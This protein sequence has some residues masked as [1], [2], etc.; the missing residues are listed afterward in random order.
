M[1]KVFIC[2]F[3]GIGMEE[4]GK[5]GSELVINITITAII[6]VIVLA[7]LL[8]IFLNGTGNFKDKVSSFF[9]ASNV[10]NV[11]QICNNDA[12]QEGKYEY[13]CVKKL[14]RLSSK[15]KYELSCFEASGKSWASSMIKLNCE[16]VC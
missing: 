12:A 13:C 10:D 3:L 14:V 1:N 16:G 7:I 4:R 5:R 2:V 9:S 6:A 8:L 11:I 15:E